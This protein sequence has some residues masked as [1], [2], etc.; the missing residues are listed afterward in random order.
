MSANGGMARECQKFYKRLAELIAEKKKQRYSVISSWVKRKISFSLMNSVGLC[1][2][3]SRSLADRNDI[4]MSMTNDAMMS[5]MS[6][7]INF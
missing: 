1:L 4:E 7:N 3:G 2:R 6:S 5:E